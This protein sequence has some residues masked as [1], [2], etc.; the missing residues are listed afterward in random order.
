MDLL[1]RGAY[2]DLGRRPMND[3]DLLL[4]PEQI[5]RFIAIAE[6]QG[7]R[8]R[9]HTQQ[10]LTESFVNDTIDLCSPNYEV[11][12]DLSRR[13]A[14]VPDTE[15]IWT[16]SA[17]RTTRLGRHR[18]LHP[19]DALL[20]LIHHIVNLRGRISPHFVQDLEALLRV[21][22]SAMQWDPWV[23]EVKR[24][25][26]QTAAFHALEYARRHQSESVPA[27]VEKRLAPKTAAARLQ[28]RYFRQAVTE[29]APPPRYLF[30]W[31]AAPGLKA[32]RSL[33]RRAFWPEPGFVQ[34][35]SG[36]Q[37]R[38]RRAIRYALKPIQMAA[39]ALWV[40]PRELWQVLRS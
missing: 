22:E 16:R 23:E 21:E 7:L 2:S 11:D 34:E 35:R 29:A 27:F 6:G 17:E 10:F 37:P 13:L 33:L 40:V 14:F 36:L 28:L 1:L 15:A 12:L 3:I 30:H 25:G 18:L 38:G 39:K 4:R 5:S 26:M 32:K 19:H 8:R 9:P 31:I 24:A 20:V